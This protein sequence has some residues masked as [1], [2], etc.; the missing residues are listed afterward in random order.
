MQSIDTKNWQQQRQ[1]QFRNYLELI[2]I[3]IS[4][5]CKK[6]IETLLDRNLVS[7][8]S[9][10]WKTTNFQQYKINL[11]WPKRKDFSQL[12][13]QCKT[14]Q[15]QCR[16]NFTQRFATFFNK[17]LYCTFPSSVRT[18]KKSTKNFS[19][20]LSRKKLNFVF[21]TATTNAKAI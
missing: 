15:I 11:Q 2:K 10:Q 8:R 20:C 4:V 19:D 12:R 13:I 9:Q 7:I 6:E 3:F 17:L 1:Q 5:A 21:S 18:L 14:I 16:E